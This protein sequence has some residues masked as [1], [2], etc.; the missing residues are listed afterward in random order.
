MSIGQVYSTNAELAVSGQK[1]WGRK[2][3]SKME[4]VDKNPAKQPLEP[5]NWSHDAPRKT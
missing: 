1:V 5:A 2:S 3:S 4:K